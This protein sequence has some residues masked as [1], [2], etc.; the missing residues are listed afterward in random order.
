MLKGRK[1]GKMRGKVNWERRNGLKK[2]FLKKTEGSGE[3]IRKKSCLN[4]VLGKT[5]GGN[6][7]EVIKG[8]KESIQTESVKN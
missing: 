8:T 4:R 5:S 6:K 1:G 7:Q 2:V 3:K